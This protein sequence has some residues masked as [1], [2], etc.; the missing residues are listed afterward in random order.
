MNI[1]MNN[2]DEPRLTPPEVVY[3]HKASLKKT[4][5]IPLYAQI[6]SA[7]AAVALVLTLCWPRS[8]ATPLEMTAAIHSIA[9]KMSVPGGGK[10]VTDESKLFADMGTLVP[11]SKKYDVAMETAPAPE[12]TVSVVKNQPQRNG[13][14]VERQP[15]RAEL[16]L[17]AALPAVASHS[18]ALTDL[19][20]STASLALLPESS[21][22]EIALAWTSEGALADEMAASLVERR[23]LQL[24]DGEHDG[25]GS[26]L[27]QG[28]RSVKVEIAQLNE[29]VGEGIRLL[30][31]MPTPPSLHSDSDSDF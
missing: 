27:K 26:M 10:I 18:L 5:V 22:S 23:F 14:T 8:S 17:L 7:A 19:G 4:A 24:T 13:Q 21:L 16:P 9:A 1:E 31:Q 2:L 12:T 30:K 6:A 11:Q 25:I 3:E 29:S 28:W 20:T 15:H